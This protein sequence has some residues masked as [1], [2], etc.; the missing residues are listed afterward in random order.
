MIH[1]PKLSSL[2]LL[3]LL[4]ACGEPAPV[5]WNANLDIN[6]LPHDPLDKTYAALSPKKFWREQEYDLGTLMAAGQKN[7]E[8]STQVLEDSLS[9]QGEFLQ[10]AQKAA[11]DLGLSGAA[12]RDHIRDNIDR[13]NKEV[14][15]IKER[16]KQQEEGLAWVRK[17]TNAVQQELRK[18]NLFPVEYDPEKRPM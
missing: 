14:D 9:Q 13:Y 3:F 16:L 15:D 1:F 2:A 7:M 17:C 10:L 5:A 4:A 6:C 11:D 12:R 8:M 18:L